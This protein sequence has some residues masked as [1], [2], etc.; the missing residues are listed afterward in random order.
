MSS[1]LQ[2]MGEIA[3]GFVAAQIGFR[4]T[5]GI[6]DAAGALL[7]FSSQLQQ[8]SIAFAT[9]T[10]SAEMAQKHLADLKSFARETPFQFGDLV[11][12]SKRLQAMGTDVNDVVDTMRV[13]GNVAS[14]VG[15]EKMPQLILAFGQVQAVGRL[16]GMELRQFT[17][18]GVPLLGEL[19]KAY[20]VTTGEMQEM[21]SEGKVGFASVKYVM[22][23]MTEEGGRI[24]PQMQN[25]AHTFATAS[26]NIVDN[27]LQIG[28]QGFSPLFTW[29]TDTAVNLADFMT[30]DGAEWAAAIQGNLKGTG[31]MFDWL[32]GRI[33]EAKR[34]LDMLHE[35]IAADAPIQNT[36][37]DANGNPYNPAIQGTPPTAMDMSQWI[38]DEQG[39]WLKRTDYF[40]AGLGMFGPE[41][42]KGPLPKTTNA[43]TTPPPMLPGDAAKG[44]K[45]A[46]GFQDIPDALKE[47]QNQ[48]AF[49][50]WREE[51]LKPLI[52][53]GNIQAA[54]D[55][56]HSLGKTNRETADIIINIMGELENKREQ[57]AKA[58]QRQ[59]E[60]DVQ[61]TRDLVNEFSKLG[62]VVDWDQTARGMTAAANQL[63]RMKNDATNLAEAS[64]KAQNT[65]LGLDPNTGQLVNGT[66]DETA[67]QK[68]WEIQTFGTTLDAMR[69]AVVE[70]GSIQRAEEH[71]QDSRRRAR[72]R[73]AR[74]AADRRGERELAEFI[75]GVSGQGLGGD[76]NFERSL[77][78]MGLLP[79][80][81]E[82]RGL[83]Q[84]LRQEGVH[85]NEPSQQR[86]NQYDTRVYGL[87][88]RTGRLY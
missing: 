50:I 39:N 57:E 5:Q 62:V 81:E 12:Y 78:G 68:A 76:S 22:E 52:D 24:G 1:S 10:G 49:K 3:G 6:T 14:G 63:E 9:M 87:Q 80:F 72:D 21:I 29:I 85:V 73:H 53:E 47:I 41:V 74:A 86:R 51:F 84:N 20:G 37:F 88:G 18:A 33:S 83:L 30:K 42:P 54:I 75:A 67:Y 44:R 26:S 38:E 2:R 61:A 43:K 27:L 71:R 58:R 13:L 40:D 15:M 32:G 8:N 65:A 48:N 25:Q 77:E 66:F 59:F 23:Q 35:I 60:Q 79:V 17:E 55:A 82:M 11:E 70:A 36:A 28:E 7:N 45:G 31:L 69:Q 34:N 19:A 46:A 64:R 4:L 56:L 16:T